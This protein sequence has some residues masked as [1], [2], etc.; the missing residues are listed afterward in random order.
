MPD[1]ARPGQD[2]EL[3]FWIF[4]PGTPRQRLLVRAASPG[5]DAAFV[6]DGVT[7][8]LPP[9]V[10]LA[11]TGWPAADALAATLAQRGLVIRPRALTLTMFVRLFLAD[12]FLHGIGGALYDQITDGLLGELFGTVP[13]Y[14]CVSAAWLLPLGDAAN[15]AAPA[16]SPS[17]LAHR[18]HHLE[19]NPHLAIDPFTARQP[20]LAA[21]LDER[22][23]LIER[24]R[25]TTRS[26]DPELKAA[27]RAL[28]DAIHRVN[29]AIHAQHPQALAKI[30]HAIAAS[31]AT[32]INQQ[33]WRWREY[34]LG[35]HTLESLSRLVEAIRHAHAP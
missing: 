26:R 30:D 23:G 34:Y 9:P 28:F 17:A 11:S 10:D 29:A 16:D 8:P 33:V 19:H 24:M 2:Q 18:R 14:G 12:L 5:Q 27:R 6:F 7:I 3:P 15:G 21:L 25:V 22:T 32:L 13:P 1:L 31:R 4:R 20:A 35:L